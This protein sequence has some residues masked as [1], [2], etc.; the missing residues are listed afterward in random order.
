VPLTAILNPNADRGRTAK[1]AEAFQRASAQQ[2]ELKLLKTTRR[3]EAA[4]LAEHAAS[5]SPVVI[6]IGG[7]GTVHEVASGLMRVPAERRPPLGVVPAGSGNDFAYALGIPK[8]LAENV[9]IIA[10]GHTRTV[11]VGDVRTPAGDQRY[12]LN[13]LGT[14]LE[15]QINR[16]SHDFTW[17]RGRGLYLRAVLAT[18]MRPPQVSQLSLDCDGRHIHRDA[19]LLS[20][21]NGPRSGG[22][23]VMSPAAQADDGR[24]NYLL[25]RPMSRLALLCQIRHALRGNHIAD[26]RFEYG[27][28]AHLTIRSNVPLYVHVDG[29]PWLSPADVILQLNVTVLPSALRVLCPSLER[30]R[31]QA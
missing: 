31:K 27:D 17:P 30:G 26:N 23:F 1:L 4:D 28:F 18:F 2:L 12:C 15:G 6:A 7:D 5:E 20:I 24:F 16:A 13:N 29:E 22:Q 25:A 9:A 10:A 19:V 11:D 3:G 21:N 8:I 14:L